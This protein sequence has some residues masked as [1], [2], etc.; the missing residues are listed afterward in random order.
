MIIV[1]ILT[2]LLFGSSTNLSQT[3]V[4]L[5]RVGAKVGASVG[6]AVGLMVPNA[7][8]S[9]VNLISVTQYLGG[10]LHFTKLTL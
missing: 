8:G 9:P 3:T 2:Y 4:G 5:Y 10:G 7:G 6:F 1:E